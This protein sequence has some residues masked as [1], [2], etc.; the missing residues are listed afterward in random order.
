MFY[1]ILSS[2]RAETLCL[3]QKYTLA[4]MCKLLCHLLLNQARQNTSIEHPFPSDCLAGGR[5][6]SLGHSFVH[7]F[8]PGAICHISNA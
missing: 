2:T 8:A 3:Y 6:G 5:S 1:W 4:Q 7:S